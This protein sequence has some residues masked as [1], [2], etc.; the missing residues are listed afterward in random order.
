MNFFRKLSANS[1]DQTQNVEKVE[2]EKTT[3]A[4]S[5]TI[6]ASSRFPEFGSQTEVKRIIHEAQHMLRRK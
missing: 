1:R 2:V 5:T 6:G 4:A 3:P